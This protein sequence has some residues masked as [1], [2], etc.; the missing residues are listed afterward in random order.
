[1]TM[2]L[3]GTCVC[4]R[5]GADL[6]NGSITEAVVINALADRDGQPLVHNLHLGLAHR[7]G[8]AGRVLTKAALAHRT[9]LDGP[10][11]LVTITPAPPPVALVEPDVATPEPEPEPPGI[12]EAVAKL[13]AP[14]KRTAPAKRTR[15]ATK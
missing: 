12:T 1:M 14:R 6:G 13:A 2:R 4:D 9:E 5:C 10:L 7:C 11:Q 8:C 3:A 15:K